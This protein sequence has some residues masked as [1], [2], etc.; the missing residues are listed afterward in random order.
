MDGDR[1]DALA[2]TLTTRPRSRRQTLVGLA[3][4]ALA[5]LSGEAAAKQHRHRRRHR[6]LGSGPTHAAAP[7]PDGPGSPRTPPPGNRTT[8]PPGRCGQIGQPCKWTKQGCEFAG[9]V[10]LNGACA[11]GGGRTACGGVCLDTQ[12]D[13]ANC[14]ACGKRCSVGQTT[15]VG[16]RCAPITCTAATCPTGNCHFCL[17]LADGGTQ[18]TAGWEATNCNQ[19]CTS[20]ADCAAQQ[21]E[22]VAPVLY[23]GET[24]STICDGQGPGYCVKTTAC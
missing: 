2:T 3:L 9:L 17:S 13:N 11:C 7:P 4:G 15:C 10:C 20:A 8:P 23:Q 19:S 12:T 14:G 21:A 6:G 5:L 24:S 16:G 22:C 1:F 18:C